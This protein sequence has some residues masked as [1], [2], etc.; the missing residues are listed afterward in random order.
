MKLAAWRGLSG[1]RLLALVAAL[2][3]VVVYRSG[4]LDPGEGSPE[5]RAAQRKVD[6]AT[7]APAYEIRGDLPARFRLRSDD[8]EIRIITNLVIPDDEDAVRAEM[9]FYGLRVRVTDEDGEEVWAGVFWERTKKTRERAPKELIDSEDAFFIGSSETPADSRST[10]LYVSDLV[11]R[12]A[13]HLEITPEVA[14]GYPILV[15]CFRQERLD[16]AKAQ[17]RWEK[18]VS[19]HMTE[20]L[21]PYNSFGPEVAQHEERL[22]FL[23]ERWLRL[24]PEGDPQTD[25]VLRPLYVTDFRKQ[26]RTIERDDAPRGVDGGPGR[27]LGINVVGPCDLSVEVTADADPAAILAPD[28]PRLLRIEGFNEQGRIVDAIHRI[29]GEGASYQLLLLKVPAG[30]A[31]F[32]VAPLNFAGNF[33]FYMDKLHLLGG[34]EIS[35]VVG[36]SGGRGWYEIRPDFGA[37]RYWNARRDPIGGDDGPAIAD[38]LPGEGAPI[39]ARV[40][41]QSREDV[42][43]LMI[44]ARIGIPPGDAGATQLFSFSYELLDEGGG[45]V[46]TE[47]LSGSARPSLFSHYVDPGRDTASVPSEEVHF[48]IIVPKAATQIRLWSDEDVGLALFSRLRLRKELVYVPEDYPKSAEI[49][50]SRLAFGRPKS[51][52]WFYFRPLN[53]RELVAERRDVRVAYQRRL[54][55]SRERERDPTQFSNF[56]R[57]LAPI[58]LPERETLWEE[59]SVEP[60]KP[61]V[62]R[63]STWSRV[64]PFVD[65]TVRVHDFLNPENERPIPL[66]IVWARL[67]GETVVRVGRDDGAERRADEEA[68]RPL[69]V[70]VYVDGEK[71]VEELVSGRAG[72]LDAGFVGQ[73]ARAVRVEV[74]ERGDDDVFEPI[75]PG[76][77]VVLANAPHAERIEGHWAE[78]ETHRLV[79]GRPITLEI[80]KRTVEPVSLNVSSFFRPPVDEDGH[81]PARYEIEAELSREERT[82]TG[83]VRPI[84]L[85]TRVFSIVCP[86]PDEGIVLGESGTLFRVGQAFFYGLR[87]DLRPGRYRL[88]M[89]L[90]GEGEV[91]VRFSLLDRA[92]FRLDR[93]RWARV[94]VKGPARLRI[95]VPIGAELRERGVDTVRL[96][97]KRQR[98]D[99]PAVLR[100]LILRSPGEDAPAEATVELPEGLTTLT[101]GALA[102]DALTPSFFLDRYIDALAGLYRIVL[103]EPLAS[104]DWYEF[105]PVEQRLGYY[106]QAARDAPLT[107]ELRPSST[108]GEA[109]PEATPTPPGD[110][111]TLP[112]FLK[113]IARRPFPPVPAWVEEETELR[114]AFED[115]GAAVVASG[116]IV[117][118][119]F[120]SDR[121]FY[122][123]VE[124]ERSESN[125][126]SEPVERFL[127]VP[128]DAAAVRFE[129]GAGRLDLALL[130]RVPGIRSVSFTPQDHREPPGVDASDLSHSSNRWK[131]LAPV[132]AVARHDA[133]RRPTVVVQ[134]EVVREEPQTIEELVAADD[135]D[136]SPAE[137][138]AGDGG[139][140]GDGEGAATTPPGLQPEAVAP[141]DYR[142]RRP[143]LEP[144]RLAAE[145]RDALPWR[146]SL[147]AVVEPGDPVPFDVVNWALPGSDVPGIVRI[148]YDLG[149]AAGESGGFPRIAV[150]VDGEERLAQAPLQRSGTLLVAGVAPGRRTIEIACDAPGSRFYVGQRPAP[151]EA[152]GDGDGGDDDPGRP[153]LRER[154]LYAF[155]FEAP[156]EAGVVRARMPVRVHKDE[157]DDLTLNLSLYVPVGVDPA[158]LSVRIRHLPEPGAFRAGVATER[159]TVPERLFFFG[160]GEPLTVI[161]QA[162]LEPLELVRWKLHYTLRGDLVAGTHEVLIELDGVSEAFARLI[163]FRP[164]DVERDRAKFQSLREE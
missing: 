111:A 38:R 100:D 127:V 101:I 106:R 43:E 54:L 140:A 50:R 153:V 55:E 19:R 151:R 69:L 8:H 6:L 68:A 97:L 64:A 58:G 2:S 113:L 61:I 63:S 93:Q 24:P 103:D 94:N 70:I 161:D 149:E 5:Q 16:P 124:G 112:R 30:V 83:E 10:H 15:R 60:G 120:P 39:V 90:L 150:K 142:E 162:R 56:G 109:S 86:T 118:R 92:R 3:A 73:G 28:E 32:T 87:S 12:G 33:R 123:H 122:D 82:D 35:R 164:R 21:S 1:P 72:Q 77:F 67:T 147:L 66:P 79:R 125:V 78:R 114:Y 148:V 156:D 126:P 45:V 34:Q 131:A 80:N 138:A 102:P 51:K 48:R 117:L 37:V 157:A 9:R 159:Y 7:R 26:Q 134:R 42:A 85:E 158:D 47:E 46:H 143:V 135:V 18:Y 31:T 71:R 115:A 129:A 4:V 116:T 27:H 145:E 25:Y 62:G 96:L 41:H 52:I 155:A 160:E 139:D 76:A 137:P 29:E 104:L 146:P 105:V 154:V 89:R 53:Y 110:E 107:Y 136:D 22:R 20:R 11:A 13:V 49:R 23:S 121:D 74:F 88:V 40:E 98:F 108:S 44:S 36:R 132:D 65:E 128:A 75:D 144:V 119:T 99:E 17:Q 91:A 141:N 133:G 57:F 81:E 130:E 14:E 59:L 84:A 95:E 163:V 152:S